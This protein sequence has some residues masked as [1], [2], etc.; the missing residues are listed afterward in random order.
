MIQMV[1]SLEWCGMLYESYSRI[2]EAVRNNGVYSEY[3]NPKLTDIHTLS[4]GNQM[5]NFYYSKAKDIVKRIILFL[6]RVIL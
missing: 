2:K 3:T 6:I 1:I 5:F 4:D